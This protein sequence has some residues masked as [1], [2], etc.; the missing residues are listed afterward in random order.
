MRK[1]ILKRLLQLIPVLLFLSFAVYALLYISGGDPALKKLSAQGIAVSQEVVERTR[2]SM[3]LDRPF[4][5]RYFDW[6]L[7]VLRGDFGLSYKDGLPVLPKLLAGLK[8]TAVLALLSL[9]VSLAVSVPLGVLCAVKKDR[10]VDHVVRVL[11]FAGNALPSFLLSV[12][13]M[14]YLCIKFRLFPVIATGS[15]QGLVLPVLALSLPM[16]SRFTRQIRAEVLSELNKDYVRG[17]RAHGLRESV[18]LFKNVLQGALGAILTI[19]GLSVGTLMG[20]SVVVET[21]FRWPGIGK[22][23]MEAISAR[24]FPVIQ[25][26]VLVMAALYVGVNL[27]TDLSYPLIDKRVELE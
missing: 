4:L 10:P 21:I 5:V 23:V 7:H 8:N 6:L 20:G 24:D 9:F 25:G 2:H 22:L 16:M 1:Y 17:L 26:F 14:Y 13:L 27:L 11:S 19:V 18:V 3:G 12:L 15:L